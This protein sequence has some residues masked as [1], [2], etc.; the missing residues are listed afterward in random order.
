ML[1][2]LCG[3]MDL[4]KVSVRLCLVASAFIC[5]FLKKKLLKK[6]IRPYPEPLIEVG[7]V[8]KRDK[9]RNTFK[10]LCMGLEIIFIWEKIK[11]YDR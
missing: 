6:F 9:N 7:R 2:S 1:Q 5:R 8:H 10:N 4:K 3:S 11:N